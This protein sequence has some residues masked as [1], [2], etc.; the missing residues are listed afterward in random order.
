M[1]ELDA[2]EQ[3][4]LPR[5]LVYLLKKGK[6]SR[7]DLKNNIDASQQAIY[8]SLPILKRYGLIEEISETVFPRRKLITLTD[9]GQRVAEHLVEIEKIL[10]KEKG[11]S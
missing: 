1:T 7:T 9:K 6:A 5:I 10:V 2:L 11:E 3:T 8:N 4:A